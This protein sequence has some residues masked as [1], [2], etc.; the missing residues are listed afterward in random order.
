MANAL[1]PYRDKLAGGDPGDRRHLDLRLRQRSAQGGALSRNLARL[2]ETWIAAG[3][4]SDGRRN[5][6]GPAAPPAAGG[7]AHL[8]HRHQNL[9]RLRHY[10]PADLARMLDTKNYKVVEF[11]WN[12]KR[13]DLLRRRG[14]A[15]RQSPQPG[16]KRHRRT[17]PSQSSRISR[18]MPSRTRR[19]SPSRPLISFSASMPKPAPSRASATRRPAASGPARTTPSL[20]FT[21]QT[22]SQADYQRF[23]AAYVSDDQS[24]LGARRTS[25]SRTSRDSARVRQ[26]WQPSSAQRAHGRDGRRPPHPRSRSKFKDEEAFQSG[27]AGLSAA[28]LSSSWCCP[29]PSR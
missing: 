17:W 12:E 20:C 22:L 23:I 4:I 25:A 21:Y 13:Q 18:P 8:G 16:A 11:S 27:R 10:K 14:H 28:K 15:A 26:D 2:R 7:R 5:R 9:A 3:A 19:A 1:Q 6:S 29:R 24:R